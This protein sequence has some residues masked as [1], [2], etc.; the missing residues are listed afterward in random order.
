MSNCKHIDI[1]NLKYAFDIFM[2][3]AREDFETT[4]SIEEVPEEK[5]IEVISDIFQRKPSNS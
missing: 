4:I 2:E 1:D 3:Q 5:L